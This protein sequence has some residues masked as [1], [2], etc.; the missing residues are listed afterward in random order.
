MTT[1]RSYTHTTLKRLFALSCNACSFD[2]CEQKLADLEWDHVMAEISHIRGLNP[3]SARYDASLSASEANSFENLI[4]LCPNHHKQIDVLE[5]LRYSA[6]D[7]EGMKERHLQ[8]C[9]NPWTN[10]EALDTFAERLLLSLDTPGIDESTSLAALKDLRAELETLE[11][12]WEKQLDGT[13][14]P[15][16]HLEVPSLDRALEHPADLPAELRDHLLQVREQVAAVNATVD[17]ANAGRLN[18]SRRGPDGQVKLR[19]KHLVPM[20]Q[21]VLPLLV[22]VAAGSSAAGTAAVAPEAITARST[23]S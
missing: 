18:N 8:K 15:F 4:I 1:S 19:L 9:S 3:G 6:E 13:K 11:D 7:L 23:N 20:I 12:R 14:P 16:W 17:A 2:R 22:G 10:D 5:P 21:A